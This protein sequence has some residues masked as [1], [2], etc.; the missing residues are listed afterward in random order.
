MSL[1]NV[2]PVSLMRLLSVVMLTGSSL[3]PDS[4]GN[5][6]GASGQGARL[7]HKVSLMAH[8][9]EASLGF[10]MCQSQGSKR[11]REEAARLFEVEALKL[12]NITS[13]ATIS[14][15]KSQDRVSLYQEEGK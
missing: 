3:V 15:S 12:H 14:Y 4:L 10:F 13:A 7:F 6:A 5:T 2:S 11:A 9:Q 8:L 1:L